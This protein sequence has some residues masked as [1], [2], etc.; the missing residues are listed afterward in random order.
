VRFT[1]GSDEF[2]GV[3]RDQDGHVRPVVF[4]TFRSFSQA[5]EENGQ[6]RIYLG[7]HWSFDKVEGMRQGNAI[8]DYVF[9][10]FLK[11]RHHGHA[12]GHADADLGSAF[13]PPETGGAKDPTRTLATDGNVTLAAGA[14]SVRPGSDRTPVSQP[15]RPAT[16]LEPSQVIVPLQT[17][18]TGQPK[19]TVALGG[20]AARRLAL[21]G[22]DDRTFGQL[23]FG[24]NSG[25]PV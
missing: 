5:A 9:G 17:S 18:G 11:P 12:R 14:G 16:G 24:A 6:S 1:I 25:H 10:H 13:V 20:A 19:D 7:I 21:D 4:R 23:D 15:D 22:T 2:N 8:A 3:T